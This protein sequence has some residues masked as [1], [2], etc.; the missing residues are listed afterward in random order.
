MIIFSRDLS[1]PEIV[2][3]LI[4][5]NS[6]ILRHENI[7]NQYLIKPTLEH[8]YAKVNMTPKKY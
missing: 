8:V 6:Q 1:M 2:V 3:M 7:V 4:L 5:V